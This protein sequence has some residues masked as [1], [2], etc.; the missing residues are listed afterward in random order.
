MTTAFRQC[1]LLLL[2]AAAALLAAG[3]ARAET[4][5]CIELDTLPVTITEPGHYCLTHDFV[6]DFG[7]EA[8]IRILADDVVLDCNDHRLKHSNAANTGN[9]IYGP[10]ERHDVTIRHCVLDGW[11]VGLFLQASS[12]PGAS[13]N[14]IEDNVVLRSRVAGIYVI[15]SHN[16]IDRNRVAQNNANYGGVAYGIF[17]VSMDKTG[18]GN[19]VRDNHVTDFKPTPPGTTATVEGITISNLHNTEVSGNVIAGLYNIEGQYVAGIV[20]YNAAGTS[21]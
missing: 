5:G 7:Y 3:R 10:G 16:R 17:V 18:V 13:G 15:G 6:Q 4:T 9:A 1:L 8:P 21:V 14:R 11:Y 12:D 20:G 19:V 2:V